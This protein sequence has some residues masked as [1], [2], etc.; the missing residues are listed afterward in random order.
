MTLYQ[1]RLVM[2]KYDGA[3]FEPERRSH[4][5]TTNPCT[6][7]QSVGLPIKNCASPSQ[8]H[9]A[10]T[11]R[12]RCC[13]LLVSFKLKDLIFERD[14][15]ARSRLTDCKKRTKKSS[16]RAVLFVPI[17]AGSDTKVM[18]RA[19]Q[20]RLWREGLRVSK[21]V[22]NVAATI[23]KWVRFSVLLSGA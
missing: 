18:G 1:K 13:F 16:V 21:G 14:L 22:S 11:H 12:S 7:R 5:R 2:R 20:D 8:P 17:V 6:G 9:C 15:F 3:V 19:R 10:S 23:G 4:Q